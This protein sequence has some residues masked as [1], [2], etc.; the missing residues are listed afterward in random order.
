MLYTLGSADNYDAVAELV[1]DESWSWNRLE[2]FFGKVSY[3]N[4]SLRHATETDYIGV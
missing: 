2:P 3:P 1:D 4:L